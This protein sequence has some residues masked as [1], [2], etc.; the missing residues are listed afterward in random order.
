MPYRVDAVST[1]YQGPVYCADQPQAP[2][3]YARRVTYQIV[4]N[5]SQPY[6]VGGVQV[7]DQF[8]PNGRND[9][10]IQLSQTTA[11]GTQAT[12]ANG[13]WPDTLSLCSSACYG[14]TGVSDFLQQWYFDNNLLPGPTYLEFSCNGI[15]INGHWGVGYRLWSCGWC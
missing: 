10:A 5:F 6:R 9:L 15:T 1:A 4:D 8:Q 2:N 11:P 13:Q 3:G 14:S 7:Y 12:D